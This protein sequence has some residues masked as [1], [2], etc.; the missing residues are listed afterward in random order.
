MWGGG[1]AIWGDEI[2]TEQWVNDEGGSY[3]DGVPATGSSSGADS[4]GGDILE[5]READW[6]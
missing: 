5:H 3:G 6:G 4:D 1:W 2:L